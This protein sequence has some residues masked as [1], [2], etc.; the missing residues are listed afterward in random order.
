[1]KNVINVKLP[2]KE[3]G[4]LFLFIYSKFLPIT[5]LN[6]ITLLKITL[7]KLHYITITILKI[8]IRNNLQGGMNGHL[9]GPYK[10]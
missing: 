4:I 2:K 5:L 6:I 1:M 8:L 7:L 3:V 10:F 9:V